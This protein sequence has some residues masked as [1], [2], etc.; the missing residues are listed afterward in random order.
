MLAKV[1]RKRRFGSHRP[2]FLAD[3]AVDRGR[4][5]RI[6]NVPVG[7]LMLEA[8]RRPHQAS[9]RGKS[10]FAAAHWAE[11]QIRLAET[12]LGAFSALERPD[13]DGR[14]RPAELGLPDEVDVAE[15]RPDADVAVASRAQLAE[16][17]VDPAFL[18]V[19]GDQANVTGDFERI[20]GEQFEIG[21]RV[22]RGRP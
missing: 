8:D 10:E 9:A 1:G 14:Y 16:P 13:H 18:A 5:D 11:T 6:L 2:D 20:G 17:A 4:R 19:D 12:G 7:A 3:P 21:F 22:G 15:L